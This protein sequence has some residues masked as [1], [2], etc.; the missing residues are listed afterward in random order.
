MSNFAFRWV[1]NSISGVQSPRGPWLACFLLAQVCLSPIYTAKGIWLIFSANIRAAA[2]YFDGLNSRN[3]TMRYINLQNWKDA[4][5]TYF[6]VSKSSLSSYRNRSKKGTTV[7]MVKFPWKA[8]KIW[9]SSLIR[10]GL[11][12]ESRWSF[13]KSEIIRLKEGDKASSSLAAIKIEMVAKQTRFGTISFFFA[14]MLR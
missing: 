9:V 11:F 14:R 6:S 3:S 4:Y 2:A 10:S 5:L 13:C 7:M 8:R 12:A 1:N